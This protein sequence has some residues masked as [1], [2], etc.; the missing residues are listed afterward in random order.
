M[1]KINMLAGSETCGK[2][3]RDSPAIAAGNKT[4]VAIDAVKIKNTVFIIPSL[5]AVLCLSLSQQQSG[6]FARGTSQIFQSLFQYITETP[7]SMKTA[8]TFFFLYSGKKAG[9]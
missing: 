4:N 6:H 1:P 9:S 3:T 5:V 8:L 7:P 2:E